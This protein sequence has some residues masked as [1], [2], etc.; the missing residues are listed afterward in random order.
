ML[1]AADCW[2]QM[3]MPAPGLRAMSVNN[4]KIWWSPGHKISQN[5]ISACI[6]KCFLHVLQ[7]IWT[8][9]RADDTNEEEKS[10]FFLQP[11]SEFAFTAP[12]MPLKLPSRNRV[13]RAIQKFLLNPKSVWNT[14]LPPKKVAHKNPCAKSGCKRGPNSAEEEW[15]GNIILSFDLFTFVMV[16]E[17]TVN[18]NIE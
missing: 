3:Y 2:F 16:Q 9:E 17:A 14:I 6:G 7:C 8:H 5:I 4:C 1:D 11:S 12:C 13:A 15:N 10:N 18:S